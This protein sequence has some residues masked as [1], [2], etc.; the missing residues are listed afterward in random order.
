MMKRIVAGIREVNRFFA[1]V[2]GYVLLGLSF[3]ITFGIVARHFGL[4]VQ[5][6]DEVGGYIIATT[7]TFSFAYALIERGHTRVDLVIAK[8]PRYGQVILNVAASLGAAAVATFM[9][10]FGWRALSESLLFDSHSSTTLRTPIWIPQS[11]WFAGLFVFAAT[12]VAMALHALELALTN[13]QAA[14]VAYGPSTIAE[15]LE[16]ELGSAAR[17]YASDPD[18]E[19]SL[20]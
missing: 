12:A 13:P 7:G 15:E 19:G 14:N 11:I 20:S 6:I 17:R 1:Y 3:Y 16:R 8:L 18:T 2:S 10:T 5:G 4:P 9:M